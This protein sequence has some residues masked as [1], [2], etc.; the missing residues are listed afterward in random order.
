MPAV[1][2]A[3]GK[4]V[5]GLGKTMANVWIAA[6][7]GC[8]LVCRAEAASF[9]RNVGGHSEANCLCRKDHLLQSIREDGRA[10][11]SRNDIILRN[12]G[13][14]EDDRTHSLER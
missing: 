4:A 2:N 11:D 14:R 8:E 3:Q 9:L 12:D 13:F 1:K 10:G 7:G 5:K 6:S